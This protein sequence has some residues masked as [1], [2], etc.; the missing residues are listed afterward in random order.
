MGP[1]VRHC[2][3]PPQRTCGLPPLGCHSQIQEEEGRLSC[4]KLR[5]SAWC[6][7][8][9]PAMSNNKITPPTFGESCPI[10]SHGLGTGWGGRMQG[11]PACTPASWQCSPTVQFLRNT[12]EGG[13]WPDL[14]HQVS[15]CWG[16]G[17]HLVPRLPPPRVFREHLHCRTVCGMKLGW[18]DLQ[19]CRH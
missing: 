3:S 14:S 6:T 13:R 5:G 8:Q 9:L 17:A 12:R 7:P 1:I 10:T 11:L 15:T 19:R 2:L 16:W 4:P 18:E